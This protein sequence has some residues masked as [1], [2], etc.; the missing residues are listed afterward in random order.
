MR[1]PERAPC[2]SVRPAEF[3]LD[4]HI[5]MLIARCKGDC[6]E[7]ILLRLGDHQHSARELG[8]KGTCI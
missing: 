2:N 7:V 5:G 1:R 8:P 6:Q 3:C 4:V